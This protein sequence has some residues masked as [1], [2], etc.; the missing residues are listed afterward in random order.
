MAKQ[1]GISAVNRKSNVGGESATHKGPRDKLAFCAGYLRW[2]EDSSVGF[3]LLHYHAYARAVHEFLL[4]GAAIGEAAALAHTSESSIRRART[5][6]AHSFEW[7][8][9][10]LMQRSNTGERLTRR[11]I[12]LLA[13]TTLSKEKAA[14]AAAK[15]HVGNSRKMEEA[16][17]REKRPQRATLSSEE[18]EPLAE[19]PVS[20][21]LPLDTASPRHD[22]GSMGGGLGNVRTSSGSRGK[23][24]L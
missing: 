8:H 23:A 5:V 18:T 12:E 10:K 24:R 2:W 7:F 14:L 4:T 6:G 3:L 13:L 1:E 21:I 17:R 19:G 22:L 9:E 11:H 20:G 16:T 15:A